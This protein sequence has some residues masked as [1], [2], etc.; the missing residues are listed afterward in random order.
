MM[1]WNSFGVVAAVAWG[2]IALAFCARG[3]LN[4]EAR[5][6]PLRG[7]ATRGEANTPSEASAER[8]RVRGVVFSRVSALKQKTLPIIVF[9][10]FAVIATVEA[11][12]PTN[13]VPPNLNAPLPQMQ[14][15]AGSFQTGFT[16]LT[17]LEHLAGLQGL[18]NP[19]NLVNP[20]QLT[21][22]DIARG[23]T[24]VEEDD[25]AAAIE[26]PTNAVTV[27]NWH[28]HGARSSIGNNRLDW[29]GLAAKPKEAPQC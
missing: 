3:I 23:Y 14:S 13:N 27:G 6:R 22:T 17:G 9:L 29:Q 28:L 24:L 15:G 16:G 1:D 25:D 8:R 19:V 21:N 20:V 10:F 4:A 5:N 11:Q 7:F 2:V 26:I 18:G 12:K